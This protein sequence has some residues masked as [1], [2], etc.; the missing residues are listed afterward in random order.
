MDVC[1]GVILIA[2]GSE[3]QFAVAAH[4]R[5]M[6][7]GIGSRVVS[8]PGWELFKAQAPEYRDLVLPPTVKA[9]V[10]IEAAV[11]FGWEQWVGSYGSVIGLDRF[12]ASA[13]YQMLYQQFGFTVDNVVQQA[14]QTIEKVKNA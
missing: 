7:Q 4:Y 8:M 11:T 1:P 3:V 5:L 13:P 10:A 2:S 14:L 9:R 12:G 6:E